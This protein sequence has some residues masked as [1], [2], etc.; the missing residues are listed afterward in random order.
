MSL[1]PQTGPHA[2]GYIID[3]NFDGDYEVT[4]FGGAG[5]R[6]FA[7]SST[8]RESDNPRMEKGTEE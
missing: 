1:D 4:R 2:G 7:P 5:L 8:T 3:Y 6:Q